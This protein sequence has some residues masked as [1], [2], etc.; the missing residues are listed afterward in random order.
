MDRE[1]SEAA[2]EAALV[3]LER[4]NEG[5][6]MLLT[7][8]IVIAEFVDENSTP[9]LSGYA[10]TGMPY[11]RIDGLVDNA[12]EALCYVDEDADEELD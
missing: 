4:A 5:N 8:W 9:I 6:G 2:L 12:V 3:A 1:Q 7:G 11:W 10:R